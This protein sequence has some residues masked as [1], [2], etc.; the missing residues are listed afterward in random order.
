MSIRVATLRGNDGKERRDHI[1]N[2]HLRIKSF[3]IEKRLSRLLIYRTVSIARD[4]Q[5]IL[6]RNSASSTASRIEPLNSDPYVDGFTARSRAGFTV[7][8]TTLPKNDI[9]SLIL[10]GIEEEFNH[11][12]TEMKRRN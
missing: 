8:R 4:K 9:V 11:L 12:D 1:L 7:T 3:V 2:V 10:G 5:A 6:L